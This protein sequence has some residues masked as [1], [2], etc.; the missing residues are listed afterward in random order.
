ML[1]TE[2]D[3]IKRCDLVGVG[4]TLLEEQCHCWDGL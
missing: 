2:S 1:G 4:A 3:I